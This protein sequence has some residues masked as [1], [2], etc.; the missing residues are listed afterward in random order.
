MDIKNL[1]NN[2]KYFYDLLTRATD[3][4]YLLKLDSN[5]VRQQEYRSKVTRDFCQE[6]SV[7]G[8]LFGSISLNDADEIK[9]SPR[10]QKLIDELKSNKQEVYGLMHCL[11]SNRALQIMDIVMNNSY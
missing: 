8:Q 3:I 7:A 4:K 10:T 5:Y 11:D 9:I 6:N 2:E 1:S